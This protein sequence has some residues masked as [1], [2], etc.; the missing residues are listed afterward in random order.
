MAVIPSVRYSGQIETGD[1][2]YPQ[3]KARNAGAFQDG[4]GTPLERDWLNDLW[5]FQQA[6]LA[7]AEIT[8][9]GTP[10]RVGASQYL[11]AVLAI[12][13]IATSGRHL[14]ALMQMRQ[15]DL[16]GVTP[17]TDDF[18]AAISVGSLGQILIVKG[19]ANGVFKVADTARVD[20]SGINST[21]G[22]CRAIAYNGSNR[23]VAVGNGG[24]GSAFS[25]SGNSWT[26]GGSL[27]GLSGQPNAIVWDGTEFILLSNGGQTRHSTNGGTWTAPSGDDAG[28]AMSASARSLA[29]LTPGTVLT[30]GNNGGKIARTLDH[31]A[32]WVAMTPIPTAISNPS[33][34]SVAGDGSGEV[35]AFIKDGF[36]SLV[37]CWATSD[38]NNWVER[39]EH[40]GHNDGTTEF[41][42]LMCQNT[43]LVVVSTGSNPARVAASP[44][45][46]RT[47]SPIAQYFSIDTDTIAVARARIFGCGS[48][49][50]LATDPL[51]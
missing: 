20:T 27:A 12:A 49:R 50:I 17:P 8:P 30:I 44:D 33:L 41:R 3:G 39:S 47:W 24:T 14:R 45:R 23:Y 43:G 9:S 28:T 25:T 13:G 18:M 26:S 29:V 46:G 2:G 32:S 1:A 38:G 31:G 42:A 21:L 37:E 34:V 22:D 36:G 51:M 16:A 48:T 15:L 6:L 5:G 35:L 7:L 40:N 11:D 4:T 19:S 10:D